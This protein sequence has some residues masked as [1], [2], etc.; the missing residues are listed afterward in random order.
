MPPLGPCDLPAPIPRSNFTAQRLR[1][2]SSTPSSTQPDCVGTEAAA[3]YNQTLPLETPDGGADRPARRGTSSR[4]RIPSRPPRGPVQGALAEPAKA[5]PMSKAGP[6]A[7]KPADATRLPADPPRVRTVR[8]VRL[9]PG[10][11]PLLAGHRH[12]TAPRWRGGVQEC[13]RPRLGDIAAAR[14]VAAPQPR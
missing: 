14:A 6:S 13:T 2:H 9:R 7:A 11:R 4:Q 1:T 12:G 8:C 10:D 5:V 3:R